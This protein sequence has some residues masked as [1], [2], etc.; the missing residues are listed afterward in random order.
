MIYP[1]KIIFIVQNR[2][3][4]FVAEQVNKVNN[5]MTVNGAG[6]NRIK[7]QPEQDRSLL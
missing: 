6:R 3:Y 4:L 1:D 7:Q 5:M 2:N